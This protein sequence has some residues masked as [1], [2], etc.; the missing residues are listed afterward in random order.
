MDR[1]G[2][3]GRR[4]CSTRVESVTDVGGLVREI[5]LR[6]PALAGWRCPP[7]A[8]VV[9]HVPTDAGPVRRVYSVWHGDPRSAL[10]CLRLAVH[11]AGGPGT[12][13][14]QHAAPGDAV[15]VE[16]PRSKIGLAVGAAYHVFVGDETGAVPLLAMS[17][18]VHRS[19]GPAAVPVIGVLETPTAASEMPGVPGVP[20][21]PWVH[22]GRASAVTSP[23]LVRA[24]RELRL[25]PGVGAAYLAGEAGTCRLLARHLVETRG[26]PRSAVKVQPQWAPGKPGF[27][28]GPQRRP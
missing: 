28:A 20:P 13:W 8:H 10:V 3:D 15:D 9:V 16:P 14:A 11:A 1:Q 27:G 7:G 17:A 6:G 26:W 24:L 4:V 19:V 21:L 5:R 2:A 23:V 18:A 22:R 25:P 12:A